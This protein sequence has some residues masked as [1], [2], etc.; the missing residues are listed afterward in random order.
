MVAVAACRQIA[1]G[2]TSTCSASCSI[3]A[4]WPD[5]RPCRVTLSAPAAAASARTVA[6]IEAAHEAHRETGRH[7]VAR[8]AVID[9]AQLRYHDLDELV[10]DRGQ[11]RFCC[12]RHH[13]VARTRLLQ[14]L[15]RARGAPRRVVAREAV[16][17]ELLV[18]D[19]EQVRSTGERRFEQI[20]G[21]VGHDL[22]ARL[23]QIG[24]EPLIGLGGHE[25]PRLRSGD[26]RT[27][28]ASSAA[29]RVTLNNWSST[30]RPSAGGCASKRTRRSP[31]RRSWMYVPLSP[32]IGTLRNAILSRPIRSATTVPASPPTGADNTGR[33]PSAAAIRPTQ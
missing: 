27:P 13:D 19:L 16:G 12:S 14:L 33:A 2:R 8:T 4:A 29:A 32:F 24:D 25:R 1:K 10:V 30:W 31:S 21:E 18:T 28:R 7:G 5:A 17:D 23:D 6:Q 20:A 9:D 3:V 22:Y 11:R 15:D 26:R